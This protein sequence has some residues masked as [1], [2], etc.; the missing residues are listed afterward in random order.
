MYELKRERNNQNSPYLYQNK[1]FIV[2]IVGYDAFK[3]IGFTRKS[4]G[5]SQPGYKYNQW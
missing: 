3:M 4:M 5:A 2:K 1:I